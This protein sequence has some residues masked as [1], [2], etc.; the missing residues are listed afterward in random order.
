VLGKERMACDC[1]FGD[2][3]EL[4]DEIVDHVLETYSANEWTIS[5]R[6]G[7]VIVSNVPVAHGRNP[8]AGWREMLVPMGRRSAV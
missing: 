1:R 2:G 5:C 6:A 8:F 4:P 3:G 7:V